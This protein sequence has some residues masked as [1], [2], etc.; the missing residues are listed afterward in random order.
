MEKLQ[1]LLDEVRGVLKEEQVLRAEKEKRGE[2]FNVF[3]VLKQS[4]VELSHSAFIA[5]LLNPKGSHGMQDAFLKAFVQQLAGDL[6]LNTMLAKVTVEK[7][8]GN[9]TE[10]E[11]EG[12]RMDILV[13]DPHGH[14]IIIENKID[15][16]DQTNQLL[17]YDHYAKAHYQDYRLLYLTKD[18]KAAPNSSTGGKEL[19]Y[20]QVSYQTDMLKWLNAC[21]GLAACHPLI[22][23]TI[24]QYI[25][26][27]KEIL[28]LMETNKFIEIATSDKNVDATLAIIENAW[29]IENQIRKQFIESLVQIAKDKGLECEVDDG[30]YE[31]E[32]GRWLYIRNPKVSQAW[33][34]CI[35]NDTCSRGFYYGISRQVDE[36]TPAL[37]KKDLKQF[38]CIWE[39][40]QNTEFPLG[41]DYLW[42][43]DGHTGNWWKWDDVNTLRDMHNGKLA[44]YIETEIIDRVLNE[45]LLEKVQEIIP[46]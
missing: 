16:P 7:S 34:I 36:H 12:G 19:E 10:D 35:G 30:L 6:P 29:S 31:L 4:R 5:E 13:E 14:A 32:N 3:K 39:K 41:W 8:I 28:N 45:K 22:R 40:E 46:A 44:Q 33:S 1:N 9:K 23:E 11:T 37:R 21:V 43:E 24:R 18:G 27:L 38:P 17:R 26:N 15:A 25:T 20:L 2:N 42:G